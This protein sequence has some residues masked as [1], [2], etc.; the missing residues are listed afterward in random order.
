MSTDIEAM[1]EMVSEM[2]GDL[3]TPWHILIGILIGLAITLIGCG[4][5]P[6]NGTP[7]T[8]DKIPLEPSQVLTNFVDNVKTVH[9]V[10]GGA[11]LVFVAFKV[12]SNKEGKLKG[13]KEVFLFVVWGFVGVVGVVGGFREGC[14]AVA[15]GLGYEVGREEGRGD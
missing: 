5:S 4:G 10:L 9:M 13:L 8:T 6:P 12:F 1:N 7:N 15:R 11:V 14:Y 2:C 3:S